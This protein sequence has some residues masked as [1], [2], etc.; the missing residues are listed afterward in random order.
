[1]YRTYDQILN[2]ESAKYEI[3]YRV[4]VRMNRNVKDIK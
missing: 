2:T 3:I 4:E 1:M